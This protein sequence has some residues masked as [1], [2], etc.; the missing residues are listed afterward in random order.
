MMATIL[1]FVFG[2]LSGTVVTAYLAV[3]K[4][5]TYDLTLVDGRVR[6]VKRMIFSVEKARETVPFDKD[7]IMAADPSDR[8]DVAYLDRCIV[9]WRNKRKQGDAMAEYYIDAYQSVR[10]SIFGELL[11]AEETDAVAPG[12][13]TRGAEKIGL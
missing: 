8:D 2:F 13:A 6:W 10:I 3:K 9:F 12:D 4:C 1:I 7:E 11:P 5:E